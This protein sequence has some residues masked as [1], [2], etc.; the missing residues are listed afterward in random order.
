[1]S[2][3]LPDNSKVEFTS[4]FAAAKIVTA[5]TNASPAVLTVTGHGFTTGD[6]VLFNS[7]WEN[8]ADTLYRVTSVG[9]DTISLAGLDTTNLVRFPAGG[10]A[11]DVQKVSSWKTLH[12]VLTVDSTGGDM[13]TVEVNPLSSQVSKRLPSG[14]NPT[15]VSYDVGFDATDANLAE[16]QALTR[17]QT[18]VGLRQTLASGATTYGYGYIGAAVMPKLAK[19]SANSLKVDFNLL[20]MPTNY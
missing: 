18:K 8:A 7:D 15:T 2:Y 4:D 9:V 5:A 13:K 20:G 12:Q 10:G 3:E 6:E 14:F 16:A 1:M 11:G 19:G 17:A